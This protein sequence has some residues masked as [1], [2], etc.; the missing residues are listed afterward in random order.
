MLTTSCCC[1][2]VWYSVQC[3]EQFMGIPI[4]LRSGDTRDVIMTSYVRGGDV[5]HGK[6]KFYM[7]YEYDWPNIK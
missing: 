1:F 6:K 2:Q 5:S 4:A 7:N 3:Y